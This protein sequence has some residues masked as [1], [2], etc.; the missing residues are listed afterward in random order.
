MKTYARVDSGVVREIIQP[1]VWPE[2]DPATQDQM[3][4]EAWDAAVA[5][6]GSEI[7]ISDR[8]S[9][10]FVAECV[11]ISSVTP[12]P[13]QNWTYDGSVFAAPV[14]YVAPALTMDEKKAIQ[15]SLTSN[16]SEQI[17]ILTDATDPDIVDTV[18]PADVA[19]LKAWKQ[20]RVALSKVDLTA[21]SPAWPTAPA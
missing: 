6:A 20:Y 14:P 9:P 11:D 5:R 3:T 13:D 21:V 8:Y 2:P 15:A 19:S 16:A 12:A 17:S 4:P 18:D 7:D 10:D 1:M